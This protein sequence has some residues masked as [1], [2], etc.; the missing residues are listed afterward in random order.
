MPTSRQLHSVENLNRRMRAGGARLN[1][2]VSTTCAEYTSVDIGKRATV[3]PDRSFD[4]KVKHRFDDPHY[5]PDF[6]DDPENILG[7]VIEGA[8]PVVT[9][10]D[11]SSLLA[12]FNKRCNFLQAPKDDE[13]SD[14]EFKQAID[15]IEG[16]P[17]MFEPWDENDLDRLSWLNGF[18]SAKRKRME[19]AWSALDDHTIN[20]IRNKTLMVKIET[21]LKRDDDEWAPRAIYVGSDA[22]NAITGPAMQEAMRR[23]CAILDTD[24]S[25]VKL[26][27]ADIRFGYKRSDVNLCEH[28]TREAHSTPYIAEGDY[29]RN[30]RE[31]R[32]RVAHITDAWLKKL[33]FPDWIRRLMLESSEEYEVYA[34]ICGLK[35]TLKHQLPTGTTCTTFRNSSFNAIMFAVAMKQQKVKHCRALILGD[36]LLAALNKPVNCQEWEACVARFKMVLKA[37]APEFGGAATFLSRRLVYPAVTPCLVPKIGKALARFNVRACRNPAISDHEYMAG[38]ALS[39]A[40]EFRHAPQLRDMFIA[41][42]EHH[43]SECRDIENITSSY[44]SWFVKISGLTRPDQVLYAAMN[45]P[46]K[47]DDCLWEEWIAE[48]YLEGWIDIKE[49]AQKVITGTEYE[50]VETPLFDSLA[51]DF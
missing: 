14:I 45:D 18:D 44:D 13:I 33:G 51:I 4:F 28:L 12:A 1:V 5:E 19:T 46:H 23:L 22:H 30:D 37:A 38:K 27:P 34:P 7:P 11:P 29:S 10:Q 9:S 39:H 48:T 25:G 32:S 42:Y 41:R 6:N 24:A 43:A 16:L 20:D 40:Y 15:L 49:L 21:L 26:G 47:I 35:A 17:N 2:N 50:V 36:D 31:Q 3:V 8:I